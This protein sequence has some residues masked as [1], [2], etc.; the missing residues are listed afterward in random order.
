MLCVLSF[1][2]FSVFLKMMY[3]VEEVIVFVDILMSLRI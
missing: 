2:F 1:M 3:N